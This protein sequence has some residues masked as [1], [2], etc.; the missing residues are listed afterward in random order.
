MH[1]QT[2]VIGRS[3]CNVLLQV[4]ACIKVACDTLSMY[5]YCMCDGVN[6]VEGE[7]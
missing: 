6:G 5:I 1:E 2:T 3:M 4:G 7:M